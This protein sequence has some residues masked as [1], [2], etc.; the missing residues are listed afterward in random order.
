MH[1]GAMA[2]TVDLVQRAY[3]G[4]ETSEE[5][6]WLDPRIPEELHRLRLKIRYRRHWGLEI[7]ITR[8]RIKVTSRPADVYPIKVG[9]KGE[10][11]ELEAGGTVERAL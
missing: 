5:V 4:L 1:L 11:V 3:T 2:G 6:L 10:V 8:D 7:E 9:I